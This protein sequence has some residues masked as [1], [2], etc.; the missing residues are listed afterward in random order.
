MKKTLLAF[1]ASAAIFS[2]ASSQSLNFDGTDD[3][4]SVASSPTLDNLGSTTLTL[5]AWVYINN[6]GVNSIIRKTGDYNLY[7][8]NNNICAEVWPNGIGNTTWKLFA[9]STTI[10]LNTWTHVAFT[11]NK[12]TSTP[13]FYIN[14]N[15]EA[16]GNS[17]GT[18][19]GTENLYIGAS[20][21]YG[22]Y[23]T[24]NL[25]EIRVWNVVRTQAQIKDN[26]NCSLTTATGLVANYNFNQGTPNSNNAGVTTLPDVSGNSNNGTLSNF[27][28]SGNTSNWANDVNLNATASVMISVSSFTVCQGTNVTFTATP[29]NGGATPSYQWLK[30]GSNVGT[31]S[32]IY[33]DNTLTNTDVISCQLTPSIP[34][35]N[36]PLS[37]T[38]SV[39]VPSITVTGNG[40]ICSG[41]TSTLT[42]SGMTSYTW[43]ANAGGGTTS[44]ITLT[45]GV[46]DTYTVTGFDGTC[47]ATEIFNVH[48]TATPTLSVSGNQSICI[49]S[50]ATLTAHGAGN[51]TW[52]PGNS[53]ATTVT[54]PTLGVN[55]TYTLQGANGVCSSTIT[56]T[57]TVN[58]VPTV[59]VSGAAAICSGTSLTLNGSGTA[60]TYTWDA[61]AGSVSTMSASVSPNTTTTFTLF[62]ANGGCVN[63]ATT[64]V[65]VTPTPTITVS[66]ATIIC[67]GSGTTLTANG[68][69]TYT[70]SANAGSATV[71]SVSVNPGATTTYTID[72]N[73]G[74]CFGSGTVTVNV[75]TSPT[76]NISGTTSICSGT[77][78][79]L[80]ASG[81]TTYTWSANAASA[82]TS[83]V[84][85]TPSSTDTYTVS[86]DIG[87]GC[88]SATQTIT[89][90]VN[91]TPTVSVAGNMNICSGS[92]TALI[93]LGSPST[94]TWMP[95][96][97]IGNTYSITPTSNYTFSVSGSDISG[98]CI[99][100]ATGTVVVTPS[101][102]ITITGATNICLGS[103]TT[104]TASGSPTYTWS[105]NAGSATTASVTL[106]PGSTDTYTV[107]GEY[108]GCTDTK[109]V[110]I[111]VVTSPT[112]T[113]SGNTTICSGYYTTLTAS[114]AT[115]YTW[116]AN[117]SGSTNTVVVVS[118]TTSDTYTV[119]GDVGGGCPVAT[120]TITVT[121][122]QTPIITLSGNMHV[123]AGN[124]ATVTADGA[125]TYTWVPGNT[126]GATYT[127]TP[128]SDLSFTVTGSDA[129]GSC[130]GSAT[131]TITVVANPTV[132]IAGFNTICQGNSTVLTA[133]GANSYTWSANAGNATT[134]TVSV[135]PPVGVTTFS[136]LGTNGFGCNNVTGYSVTVNALPSVIF[137]EQP[138]T[139]CITDAAA[140]LTASPSGGTFSGTG[141]SGNLFDPAVSGLGTFTLNYVY[142][143]IATNCTAS[144][145]TVM[146]VQACIGVNSY[147]HNNSVK[148]YPNPASELITVQ[149]SGENSVLEIYNSLG[150]KVSNVNLKDETSQVNISHLNKG[151]YE[152]RITNNNAVIHQ[153]KII[154][155]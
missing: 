104:L 23:F 5:E 70:W 71:P 111:N 78:I 101:P 155:Q 88:P 21:V 125:I 30:N 149:T 122:N 64:T 147:S 126:N 58:P 43:S 4:V 133:F 121:V 117:A 95:G 37:N 137:D 132:T 110:T 98:N 96:N 116:S 153:S 140:L 59:S 2:S 57:V 136:V 112:V 120:Q 8:N 65:T 61:N 63:Y 50:S 14:G 77:T 69:G 85:L 145:T 76:L 123:C 60:A 119:T 83:T 84:S 134:S 20:S 127:A 12:A 90:N 3:I 144:D 130:T 135:T 54:T 82:N 15:T 152:A 118:P 47:S 146:Y 91:T 68:A 148:I 13:A 109:T 102:T 75:V 113:I 143:D 42:A 49:D 56:G 18:V 86:G 31:N 10:A 25:D 89:V 87:G 103:G 141:V 142:T 129:T 35:A 94:Y 97:I 80:T 17:T 28:L 74:V 26:M 151:I 38:I 22:N 36:S 131:G 39:T 6:N 52:T 16:F 24:G 108:M 79:V 138:N 114:G 62:G 11:W 106:T 67:S 7:I 41:T 66:G 19:T 48:V 93:G 51:Y 32:N 34:C 53:N 154:K 29:T 100:S 99:S 27:A 45:P 73:N 44:T 46:T 81:T 33:F 115:F 139:L 107:N 92:S 1:I 55:S 124:T 9:G 105:A 150:Q 128:S 72:G 40:G